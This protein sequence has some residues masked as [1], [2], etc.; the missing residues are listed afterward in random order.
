MRVIDTNEIKALINDLYWEY[1]R[2]SSSGK[3]TLD[4]MDQIF[5]ATTDKK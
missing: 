1:D 3:E 4:R 5:G 2:M